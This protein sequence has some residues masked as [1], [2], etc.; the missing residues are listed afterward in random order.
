MEG[1]EVAA[2]VV[3]VVEVAV[4]VAKLCVQYSREVKH[5]KDDIACLLNEVKTGVSDSPRV[6]QVV[7]RRASRRGAPRHHSRYH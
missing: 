4:K 3:A 7:L 2:S 6:Y 5:A 1:L